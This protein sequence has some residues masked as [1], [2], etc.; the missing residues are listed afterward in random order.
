MPYTNISN[1]NLSQLRAWVN[2]LEGQ[3]AYAWAMCYEKDRL[4]H[5]SLYDATQRANQVRLHSIQT[6]IPTFIIEE[7]TENYISLKKQ[8]ECPV[9]L[10][11]I[12]PE[13]LKFTKCGHK[14]C[15]TCFN[16]A[17][18]VKC[19]MCRKDLQKGR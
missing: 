15:N 11:V 6:A 14:L 7:L 10:E 4:L 3:R 9:C 17:T 18:L 16:H 12:T 19:P 8:C 1:M 2:K 5:G 13:L